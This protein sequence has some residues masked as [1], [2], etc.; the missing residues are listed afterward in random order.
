[1]RGVPI[2]IGLGAVIAAGCALVFY[3]MEPRVTEQTIQV[4]PHMLVQLSA[5]RGELN[6]GPDERS[7]YTGV[8]N[9]V[10]R[11][12]ADRA[13]S[14]LVDKLVKELPKQPSKIFV[15]NEFKRTLSSLDL[16]DTEDRERAA[17]HCERIMGVVGIKSSDGV[18]NFWLY[19]P[20]LGHFVTSKE[21]F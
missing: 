9:P 3:W 2:W 7:G 5:L 14:D 12:A 15:L 20:V 21:K 10:Q 19:G 6:F 17:N 8:H 18:L 1:M 13:F 16:S 11:A 4:T